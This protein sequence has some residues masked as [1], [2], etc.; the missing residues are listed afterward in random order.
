M[1]RETTTILL[2]VSR[3]DFLTEVISSLELLIC[4]PEFTHILCVVDGDANLYT[5]VR[6][7]IQDM[8]FNQR[9]TIQYSSSK[10]VKKF[11]YIARRK[12]ITDIHNFARK[13]L[14]NTDYVFIVEDDTIIPPQALKTLNKAMQADPSIVFAEGIEM[15]RWGINYLGA[16][17]FDDIYNPTTVTSLPYE[18]SGLEYIDAGGF[19]CSLI[20]ANVYKNHEFETYESL[21]P[22]ISMGLKLRQQGYQCVVEFSVACKHLNIDNNGKKQVLL[23]E[24][25][26]NDI[27]TLKRL[28]SNNWSIA[29]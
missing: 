9:L 29:Y 21:G 4:D 20:E 23:P 15:G 11:D 7:L 12:R 14:G 5:K 13:Q 18:E 24:M 17:K 1:T 27:V 8:K 6:T 16:W 22:D 2:T 10:P 25:V 19:Y 3:D 26:G 28:N